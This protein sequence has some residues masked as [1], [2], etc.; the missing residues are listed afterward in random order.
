MTVKVGI[1]DNLSVLAG[2]VTTKFFSGWA[3]VSATMPGFDDE[4]VKG[5][6]KRLE[7]IGIG[8][9]NGKIGGIGSGFIVSEGFNWTDIARWLLLH[10][11]AGK[12]VFVCDLA[13]YKIATHGEYTARARG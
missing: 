13:G 5:I 8:A 10:M 7:E 4:R 2:Q 9:T 3:D 1:G 6:L 11:P 12:G